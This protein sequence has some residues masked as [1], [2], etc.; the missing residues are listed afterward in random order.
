MFK[1]GSQKN[2]YLILISVL[3]HIYGCANI[4]TPTGGE[5][6]LIPPEILQEFPP[7][8]S[9]NFSSKEIRINFDEYILLRDPL[10]QIITSPPLTP[11]PEYQIKKRSLIIKLP[12]TLRPN[13]TYTM[14]FGNS[15]VDNTEGNPL[16]GYQ[17]VFSTG[18]F[19]DSLFISGKVTS[20][21]TNDPVK[22]VTVMLYDQMDD[23][24]PYK[25]RPSY[26]AR[27]NESGTYRISN[28]SANEFKLFTLKD[29]NSNYLFDQPTELIGFETNPVNPA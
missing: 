22:D 24:L 29:E 5:K 14:N 18:N 4:V 21:F 8:K 10:Q 20:A 26:F 7:N 9:I 15:I 17:Y 1:N 27:S 16:A 25:N 13:T 3:F 23:S 12:D 6:D 11:A 19:I 28:I 2:I